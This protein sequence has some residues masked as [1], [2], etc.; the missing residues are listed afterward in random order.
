MR[1]GFTL[2]ELLVTVSIIGVI[3]MAGLVIYQ[4]VSRSGRDAKRREDL[5]GISKAME[6]Y[7]TIAGNYP[8][9][10]PAFGGSFSSTG[11]DALIDIVPNDPKAATNGDYSATCATTH[12]CYAALLENVGAGNCSGCSCGLDACSFATDNTNYFCVKHAN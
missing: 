8:A 4:G 2:I 3:T 7:F 10:C 11:G 1:K 5:Q 6:Q 12:F 9:A